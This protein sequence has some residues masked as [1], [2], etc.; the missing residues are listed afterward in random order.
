MNTTSSFF[1]DLISLPSTRK[2]TNHITKPPREGE[3]DDRD[4]KDR[5]HLN[6]E[7]HRRE[8]CNPAARYGLDSFPEILGSAGH[9]F[10]MH[11]TSSCYI[12]QPSKSNLSQCSDVLHQMVHWIF[13]S[14]S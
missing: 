8:E 10:E 11:V 13:N 7:D 12:N 9:T 4:Y 14:Q 5:D 1:G 3:D 2:E 6:D